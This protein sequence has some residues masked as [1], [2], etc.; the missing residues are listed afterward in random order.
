[1]GSSDERIDE[2]LRD[3]SESGA[4]EPSGGDVLAAASASE[5]DVVAASATVE[6]AGAAVSLGTTGS[7]TPAASLPQAAMAASRTVATN[8]SNRRWRTS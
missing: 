8:S 1:M 7:V 2:D 6:A 5:G 3:A 4:T